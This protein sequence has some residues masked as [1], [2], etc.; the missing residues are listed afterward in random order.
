MR[1]PYGFVTIKPCSAA[2]GISGDVFADER[3]TRTGRDLDSQPRLARAEDAPNFDQMHD[4]GT[5]RHSDLDQVRRGVDIRR[6]FSIAA[7][8]PPGAGRR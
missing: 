2:K 6:Q 7:S 3:P 8:T 4:H 5:T 1:R